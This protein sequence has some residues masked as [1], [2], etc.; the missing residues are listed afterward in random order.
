MLA[1]SNVSRFARATAARRG[2]LRP[3]GRKVRPRVSP[4]LAPTPLALLA[5]AILR[6]GGDAFAFEF[7]FAFALRS[8]ASLA[9]SLG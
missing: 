1:P 7:E 3:H 8:R 6:L 2:P 9:T 4:L 5:F